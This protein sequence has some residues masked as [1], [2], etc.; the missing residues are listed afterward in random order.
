MAGD[1]EKQLDPYFPFE[2]SVETWGRCYN[3]L[4]IGYK[5][6]TMTLDLLDRKGKYSNGFCHWYGSIHNRCTTTVQQPSTSPIRA[7]LVPMLMCAVLMDRVCIQQAAA[8]MAEARWY[9][10]TFSDQ[11][12]L[13][14]RPCCHRKWED[15]LDNADA[16]GWP[17]CTLLQYC[18]SIAA[19]LSR[20]SAN[21]C[22]V[23]RQVGGCVCA[24]GVST[25]CRSVSLYLSAPLYP[26]PRPHTNGL[27][28][29]AV[30]TASLVTHFM[31]T[32]LM[33][34]LKKTNRCSLTH[35]LVMQPGEVVIVRTGKDSRCHGIFTKQ[36]C[37]PLTRTRF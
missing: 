35:W 33:R 29:Y 28:A 1:V 6:A 34:G 22:G 8:S 15:G 21:L 5:G 27:V 23:R 37:E 18:A 10:A 13:V 31:L 9:M 32:T 16:R 7:L 17:C 20:T 26:P 30:L 14:G 19:V 24:C 25:F 2:K 36:R 3:K 12:H 11:L 4:G